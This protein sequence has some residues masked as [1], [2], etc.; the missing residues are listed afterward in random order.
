M[1][2]KNREK[3]IKQTAECFTPESLTNEILDKLEQYGKE[4]WEENKTF[5]D[6]ACGDGGLLIPVLQR[7]IK[8]GHN[9]N[10]ALKTI[11]GADIQADNIKECRLRLLKTIKNAGIEITEE[12]IKTIFTNIVCTPLNKYPNGSLDYLDRKDAFRKTPTNKDVQRWLDGVTNHN[13]LE[14]VGHENI[15]AIIRNDFE[16]TITDEMLE[17]FA[18]M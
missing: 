7:K 18:W 4:C 1:T 3:R 12:H 10:N 15:N 13:W 17:K 8:L 5:C 2:N 9:P 6:P 16:G 11:Y 14:L